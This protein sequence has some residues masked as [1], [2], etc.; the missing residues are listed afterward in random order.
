MTLLEEVH[1]K[2]LETFG[3][4]D[5]P[6]MIQLTAPLTALQGH[7]AGPNTDSRDSACAQPPGL[8]VSCEEG[9]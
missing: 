9:F 4:V 8:H 5:K 2:S 6:E 7:P 1:Y 3:T